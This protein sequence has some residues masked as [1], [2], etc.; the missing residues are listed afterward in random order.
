MPVAFALL[1][2][3]FVFSKFFGLMQSYFVFGAW[4]FGVIVKKSLPKPVLKLFP[5]CFA[6]VVLLFQ[7]LKVF[8]FNLF[9]VEF[10]L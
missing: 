10:F 5:L 8:L 9:W 4:S 6:L 7:V 3:S 1:I 2:V